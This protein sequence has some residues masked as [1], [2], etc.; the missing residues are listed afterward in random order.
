M[1]KLLLPFLS[2]LFL[3]SCG[4]DMQPSL[5]IGDTYQGGKIAYILQ[6]GDPGYDANVTHGI[7]AAPEDQSTGI[8]WYNG[9][10]ILTGARGIALGTG[11]SNTTAIVANQGTGSYAAQLCNDLVIGKYDDWYLPSR[12]ELYQLYLNRAEVGGFASA[13]YW[14][15]TENGN[16]VA[17]I[18][19]FDSGGLASAIKFDKYRVR[20]VR[21]F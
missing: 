16:L 6:P 2:I 19:L 18:L 11:Q 15:S 13:W 12:D 20:A 17:E 9:S 10:D 1:K 8:Q 14:S 5:K 4:T 7:I 21:A 3:A